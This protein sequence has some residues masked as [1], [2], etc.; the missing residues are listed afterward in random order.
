MTALA[1]EYPTAKARR[2]KGP[3][4]WEMSGLGPDLEVHSHNRRVRST[5]MN[6]HHSLGTQF[7]KV[8]TKESTPPPLGYLGQFRLSSISGRR[9]GLRLFQKSQETLTGREELSAR[10]C[11]CFPL[12]LGYYSMQSAIRIRAKPERANCPTT[13]MNANEVWA[14]EPSG[15]PCPLAP[16]PVSRRKLGRKPRRIL[17]PGS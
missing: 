10:I 6:R 2:T 8:Q 11:F 7:R 14:D 16:T 3:S 15:P 12:E 17:R 1:T 13:A 5:P 4:F 9:F